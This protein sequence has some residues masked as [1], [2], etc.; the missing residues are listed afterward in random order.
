[1]VQ[2]LTLVL[3]CCPAR[4]GP[5]RTCS[6]QRSRSQSPHDHHLSRRKIGSRNASFA[7]RNSLR[8][9][10]PGVNDLCAF[11]RVSGTWISESGEPVR[12]E[13]EWVPQNRE[14]IP[15]EADFVCS[16]Q[17]AA[18]L[19]EYLYAHELDEFREY[20]LRT[21]E[22]ETMKFSASPRLSSLN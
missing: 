7:R 2:S 12:I 20:R 18:K 21:F 4:N 14:N 5:A 22:I 10:V 9:A 19:I 8:A 11:H 1:M 6:Y 17:L 13:F 3:Y 16:K 15:I